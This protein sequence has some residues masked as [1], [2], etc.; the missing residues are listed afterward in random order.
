MRAKKTGTEIRHEQIAEAALDL[1][2]SDGIHT[3]SVAAIAES[4]GI[5]PSAVYRHYR[6][7]DDVL[8]AI[9]DLVQTRLMG[10]V[11]A[12]RAETPNALGRLKSLLIRHVRLLAENRAIPQIVFSDGIYSGSPERKAKVRRVIETYLAEV[13]RI[14][15]EGQQ[16]G[17][18]RQDTSPE[19]TAL[20]FL[21]MI[22]PTAVLSN[23]SD[24]AFDMIAHAEKAWITFERGIA[25][26]A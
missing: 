19:T 16:E 8:D 10:N 26:G 25:A 11:I 24:G 13:Q 1:I 5:V 21:G 3:L 6:S 15:Q 23:V 7:K 9:L 2:R 12:V 14:A 22:L 4:V 18:I 17:T 20:T